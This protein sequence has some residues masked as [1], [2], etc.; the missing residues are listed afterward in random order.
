[1]S[2][3]FA[4]VTTAIKAAKEAV[5][6]AKQY[7]DTSLYQKLVDLQGQVVELSSERLSKHCVLGRNR[8]V[9]LLS[10]PGFGIPGCHRETP[11]LMRFPA[12]PP[13]RFCQ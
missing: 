4:T 12:S 6:L 9:T 7:K 3:V 8:T 11:A 1:M 13:A 5:E 10:G 2:E